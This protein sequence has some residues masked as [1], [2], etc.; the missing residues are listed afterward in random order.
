[1]KICNQERADL[2]SKILPKEL[3]ETI[4]ESQKQRKELLNDNFQEILKPDQDSE[5]INFWL[6]FLDS[7]V[8]SGVYTFTVSEVERIL[9]I[10]FDF[11]VTSD[12]FTI[13]ETA[14]SLFLDIKG[15]DFQPNLVLDW[16][17]I[18]KKIVYSFS[19]SKRKSKIIS[20]C[21]ILL[22]CEFAS[23]CR[24]MYEENATE[25]ILNEWDYLL[26]VRNKSFGSACCFIC[27]FLPV[28]KGKHTLWFDKIFSIYSYYN[29]VEMDYTFLPLFY[30]FSKQYYPEFDWSPYVPLFFHKLSMLFSVPMHP[31]E[32][33][34]HDKIPNFG[35]PIYVEGEETLSEVMIYFA[36][37]IVNLLSTSAKEVVKEHITKL[38]L[39]IAPMHSPIPQN[40]SDDAIDSSSV[41]ISL[42]IRSYGSRVKKDKKK[43]LSIP[44]L[45]EDDHKW[46]LTSIMP[47]YILDMY[48]EDSDCDAMSILVQLSPSIAIPLLFE[49]LQRLNDYPH[50]KSTSILTMKYIISAIIKSGEMAEQFKLVVVSFVND[51]TSNNPDRSSYIFNLYQLFLYVNSFDDSLIEWA[52]S[53]V[54]ASINY[55]ISSIGEDFDESLQRMSQMLDALTNLVDKSTLNNLCDIVE[56][57]ID[58][59]PIE[60]LRYIIDSFASV[61]FTK[62]CFKEVTFRNLIIV[63]SIIQNSSDDIFKTHREQVFDFL[64]KAMKSENKKIQMKSRLLVKIILSSKLQMMPCVPTNAGFSKITENSIKWN[65]PTEEDA[66]DSIQFV[67]EIEPILKQMLKGKIEQQKF[68]VTIIKEIIY[69]LV[70]AISPYHYEIEKL[71]YKN[72]TVKYP[73][74]QIVSKKVDEIT[75]ILIDLIK[76][77]TYYKIITIILEAFHRILMPGDHFGLAYDSIDTIYQEEVSV[78]K[79]SILCPFDESMN[80]YT[81]FNLALKLISSWYLSTVFTLPYTKLLKKIFNCVAKLSTYPF[82]SGCEE[83]HNFIQRTLNLY[84]TEFEDE[85]F[86]N[87][88]T[89]LETAFNTSLNSIYTISDTLNLLLS[90]TDS[91]KNFSK[92]VDIALFLCRE[93]PSDVPDDALRK[94]RETILAI[95]TKKN[96]LLSTSLEYINNERK[97]LVTNSIELSKQQNIS[98]ETQIYTIGI[99]CNTVIGTPVILE[100]QIFKFMIEYLLS[101]LKSVRKIILH[102]LTILIENLIPRVEIQNN[103]EEEISKCKYEFKLEKD[104]S[105]EINLLKYS[106]E[107]F[108]NQIFYNLPIVN[109]ENYDTTFFVDSSFNRHKTHKS[110]IMRKEEA[111]SIEFLQKHF[112][113]PSNHISINQ[114]LYEMIFNNEKMLNQF[115]NLCIDQQIN[116]KEKIE[117]DR[118]FFWETLFRFFGPDYVVIILNELI[119]FC[120]KSEYNTKAF[121]YVKNEILLSIIS[122]STYFNYSQ[123]LGFQKQFFDILKDELCSSKSNTTFPWLISIETILGFRDNRRYFWLFD[124]LKSLEPDESQKSVRQL[125]EIC[126]ILIFLAQKGQFEEILPKIGKLFN[127]KSLG[128]SFHRSSVISL[129]SEIFSDY[130]YPGITENRHK[131][132]YD[133]IISSNDAFITRWLLEEFLVPSVSSINVMPFCADNIEKWINITENKDEN[134]QELGIDALVSFFVSDIVTSISPLPVTKSFSRPIILRILEQLNPTD[135]KW[136]TQTVIFS[137][138]IYF[139]QHSYFLIEESDVEEIIWNYISPALLNPNTNVQDSASTLLSFIFSNFGSIR[140]KISIFSDMFQK[141]LFD[142]D[143]LQRI[144]G[145]KGLFAIISST[146]IFDD[147]PDYIV[148]AFTSLSTASEIDSSVSECINQF[149]SDFWSIHEENFT[150]NAAIALSPF[151]DSIR[152]SYI[153]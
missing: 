83:Y 135:K 74:F 75:D 108:K 127:S 7:Y 137:M 86:P 47:I 53:L 42:L 95:L 91:K 152:P 24:N 130:Y 14:I 145:A 142:K 112:K 15:A 122:A 61:R 23:N 13:V 76:P 82:P 147:V 32:E 37:L 10:L 113:D 141:M 131:L 138:L 33:E 140:V 118:L 30:Y 144:A 110:L 77:D 96:Y 12:D 57:R 93:L 51:I 9:K 22:M 59:I 78:T 3:T 80:Q 132:F 41:F 119:N 5:T 69:G 1:M 11:I 68:A 129:M 123:I 16:K 55:S 71:K 94:L 20:S 25:E 151:K 84:Q 72:F 35:S 98:N 31:I 48:H 63:I 27:L 26:D 79:L 115:L 45:T 66:K 121:Q 150:E 46:F 124:F 19:R 6:H 92:I 148:S 36:G 58:E 102:T 111:E 62:W 133:Y 4:P 103:Y 106:E 136:Q 128:L 126:K 70:F 114:T 34:R 73:V 88:I 81:L 90:S 18:Y 21:Y 50:L 101:D 134:E 60:N 146:L 125:S 40:V 64:V 17:K 97:R 89:Y 38:F 99:I 104:K 28:N 116:H 65:I 39:L 87:V 44:Q 52:E 49:A 149:F 54:Q 117:Y 109:S 8:Q 29:S 139:L 107:R 2:F 67:D 43:R 56:K 85:F 105:E 143:S 100:K 153:S 120:A